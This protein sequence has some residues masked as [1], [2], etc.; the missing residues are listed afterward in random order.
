ML[1]HSIAGGT[2]SGLGSFLLERLNDRF[3]KKLIQTYSV[4]PGDHDTVVVQPYNSLLALRRLTQNADSVVVLDNGAL[5]RIT[6]DT[7]HVQE[8]SFQQTNKLV[9]TIMS[10]ST[11]TLRY[12]GYMHNDLVGIVASLIPTP[13]CHFLQTSYTPFTGD[14]VEATRTVRKTTVLDVMRRLLQPKNQMV[15][16]KASKTSCYI[17]ILNI[18]MGEADPTDVRALSQVTE[19][20]TNAPSG[21]QVPP[22][23]PRTQPRQ[24]YPL[25]SG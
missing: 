3:P 10:A 15:S 9:S 1:L 12:P 14:N 4:F 2:G 13:R 11:T 22:P 21:S 16:T 23:H 8:P 24:L 17:S 5:T 25:G 7:L 18:I 19:I 20:R 6:Q